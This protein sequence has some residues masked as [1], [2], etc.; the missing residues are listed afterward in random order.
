MARALQDYEKAKQEYDEKYHDSD[1]EMEA[2]H[3]WEMD[4]SVD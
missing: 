2:K 3:I 4:L 1:E